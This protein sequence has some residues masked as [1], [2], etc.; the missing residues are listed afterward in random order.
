MDAEGAVRIA[1]RV[2][3]LGELV[4]C[5]G[6]WVVLLRVRHDGCGIQT[7]EGC[8]HDPQFIQLPHQVGHDRLQRTVVQLP[9][10]AVIRPVG[11]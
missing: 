1:F 8:V 4:L 3:F 11:R 9:Q 2:V 6:F 10:A 5:K 7:D